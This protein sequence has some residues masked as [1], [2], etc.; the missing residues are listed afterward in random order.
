MG[1]I[2]YIKELTKSEDIIIL[3]SNEE[4]KKLRVNKNESN[5]IVRN[6]KGMYE[7]YFWK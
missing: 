7:P 2:N 3:E 6:L 1:D 5:E 4:E